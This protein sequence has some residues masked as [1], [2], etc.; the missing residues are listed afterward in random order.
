MNP[1]IPEVMLIGSGRRKLKLEIQGVLKE[2][3]IDIVIIEAPRTPF[4]RF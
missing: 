1:I 4:P 2:G 3:G